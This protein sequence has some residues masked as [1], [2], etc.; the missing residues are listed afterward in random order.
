MSHFLKIINIRLP[1]VKKNVPQCERNYSQV[2]KFLCNT[3]PFE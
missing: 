3:F 1:N 2:T